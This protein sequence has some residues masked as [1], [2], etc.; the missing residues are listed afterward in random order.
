METIHV[1][2]VLLTAW[3]VAANNRGDNEGNRTTLHTITDGAC[4]YT[5]ISGQS[6]RFA[7]RQRFCELGFET[8]RTWNDD[9]GCFEWKDP[10]FKGWSD[11]TEARSKLDKAIGV[12]D[13]LIKKHSLLNKDQMNPD[14]RTKKERDIKRASDKVIALQ[15]DLGT[16]TKYADDEVFGVMSVEQ[17]SESRK[18]T[19]VFGVSMGLSLTPYYGDSIMSCASPGASQSAAKDL[20]PAP[21]SADAHLTRYQFT[22]I[23]TP[24]RLSNL[25]YSEGVVEASTSPG[26]VGGNHAAAYRSY[27]AESAVFRVCAESCAR[28]SNCFTAADKD[29]QQVHLRKLA[30]LIEVGDVDASEIYIGGA[31]VDEFTEEELQALS[32][33]HMYRGIRAL[34]TAV[35]DR[36]RELA[37][38]EP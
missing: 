32:G 12:R 37:G 28:I 6:L 26:K 30:R 34:V 1:H 33:A 22:T 10:R 31:I 7:I 4:T 24:Q 8:N 3:G 21:Y 14:V 29:G 27:D 15:N 20:N 17:G 36:I 19:S 5:I 23:L 2:G 18:H 11:E 25:K 9:R 16:D 13:D 38:A 35:N